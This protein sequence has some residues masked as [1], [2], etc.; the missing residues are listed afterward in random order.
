MTVTSYY[1]SKE[2]RYTLEGESTYKLNDKDLLP[3]NVQNSPDGQPVCSKED[4][5]N[6]IKRE[7]SAIFQ[8]HFDNIV[9]LAGAGASVVTKSDGKIDDDY[10]KTMNML[11][12]AISNYLDQHKEFFTLYEISKKCHYYNEKDNK[13]ESDFLKNLNFENLISKIKSYSEFVEIAEKQKYD[14]TVEQIF[15]KIIQYTNYDYNENIF[16]HSALINTLNNFIKLPNKLT[17]VTTNYDT[18]FEDAAS[19]K[20]YTVFDGFTF[21]HEPRFDSDMFNWNLVRNI[22]NIKTQEFEYKRNTINLIKLHGSL[23]W[24]RKLDDIYRVGKTEADNPIMIFP[25]SEKYMQ[26]Y[27]T[28]YFELF[29]TFQEILRKQNTLLITTGFSFQDEHISQMIT[30]AIHHNKSLSVLVSDYN[31]DQDN[32]FW[33]KLMQLMNENYP[34][35][36]LKASLNSNLLEYIGDNSNEY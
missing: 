1:I 17:I 15:K 25:S 31:I 13:E 21:S 12:E 28:P 27:Q 33:K 9:V 11:A 8:K 34:I 5:E 22:D 29:T 36:F 2:K 30:G 20:N 19:L 10:G 26:S 6:Y 32:T 23:T 7:V 3:F 35:S 4:F 18:L 24:I 16:K 14:A